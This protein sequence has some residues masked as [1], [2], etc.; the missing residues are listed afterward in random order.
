MCNQV[1]TTGEQVS[2]LRTHE[3]SSQALLLRGRPK[4]SMETSEH[5][6]SRQKKQKVSSVS[7][8]VSTHPLSRD[9]DFGHQFYKMSLKD[10]G[11]H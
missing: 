1:L 10:R 8:C 11:L 7:C 3:H 6:I 5:Y 2:C 9:I 4:E